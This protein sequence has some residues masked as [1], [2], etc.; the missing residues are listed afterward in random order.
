VVAQEGLEQHGG[1]LL[2][3]LEAYIAA[4]DRVI[5]LV[6]SAYGWEPEAAVRLPDTTV[7]LYTRWEYCF[8]LRERLDAAT[9]L[10][11]ASRQA[12][13]CPVTADKKTF[14][15]AMPHSLNAVIPFGD[16]RSVGKR[17]LLG[18]RGIRPFEGLDGE[19]E[20]KTP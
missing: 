8:A 2:E 9:S 10:R 13:N 18:K 12:L 1:N 5:A 20:P 17:K 14:G 19:Y 7:R 4:C 11:R 16:Y 3:K 15:F 6:G